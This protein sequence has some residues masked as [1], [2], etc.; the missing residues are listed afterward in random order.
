MQQGHN[1]SFLWVNGVLYALHNHVTGQT[2][3]LEL[4]RSIFPFR[5]LWFPRFLGLLKL[6]FLVGLLGFAFTPLLLVLAVYPLLAL[7]SRL[8]LWT[9]HN[10]NPVLAAINPYLIAPLLFFCVIRD[11]RARVMNRKLE[12][13]I[14]VALRDW[15]DAYLLRPV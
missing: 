9:A 2:R 5:R 12:N 11:W 13:E 15:V 3:F 14:Q 1:V 10:L 8:D 6:V 4:P 7:V